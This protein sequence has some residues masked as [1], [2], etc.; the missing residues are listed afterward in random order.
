MSF[1]EGRWVVAHRDRQK[2]SQQRGNVIAETWTLT[3]T[4]EESF[5]VLLRTMR[6]KF[7]PRK[8]GEGG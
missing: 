1:Q 6:E 8:E 3:E 5:Q 2:G 7:S 4:K